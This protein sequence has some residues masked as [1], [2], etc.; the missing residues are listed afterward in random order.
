[1]YLVGFFAFLYP[2]EIMDLNIDETE[3]VKI[4]TELPTKSKL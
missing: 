1:M 2:K 3:G 4:L